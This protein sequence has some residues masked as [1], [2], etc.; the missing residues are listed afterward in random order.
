MPP[1]LDTTNARFVMPGDPTP[2]PDAAQAKTCTKCGET[3]ALS[4]YGPDRR[5]RD[6]CQARCRVCC[7]A[8]PK[9]RYAS[10]QEYRDRVRARTREWYAA[11]RD[12]AIAYGRNYADANRQQTRENARRWAADN[13]DRRREIEGRRHAKKFGVATERVYRSVVFDR[14]SGICH[15]CG[16]SVDPQCWHLDH[17]VALV[18]GGEHTYANVAVS[19]PLCNLKKGAK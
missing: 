8:Y 1:T 7:R 15:I 11:N 3:K 6:G 2:N 12:D 5:C 16:E 17:I 4:E 18:N 19:H 13:R 14:D 9:Q 10:D